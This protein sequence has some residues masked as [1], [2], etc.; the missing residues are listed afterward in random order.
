M[1]TGL[2]IELVGG[3]YRKLALRLTTWENHRLASDFKQ[4]AH[5][6]PNPDPD[7]NPNPSPN[8]S[9]SPSPSP[10]PSPN[11]NPNA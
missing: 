4:A 2:V 10:G 1:Y 11:P 7:P 9:P 6:S 3:R 8:P 5:P